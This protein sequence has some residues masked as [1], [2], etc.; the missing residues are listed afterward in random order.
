MNTG[1]EDLSVLMKLIDSRDTWEEVFTALEASRKP[2]TD[3]MQALSKQRMESFAQGMGKEEYRTYR[4]SLDILNNS[5][6]NSFRSVERLIRFSKVPQS[7]ILAFS[8]TEK[9][10]V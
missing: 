2:N 8:D 5:Y 3:A 9:D 7:A 4:R 6:P 10:I 1:L